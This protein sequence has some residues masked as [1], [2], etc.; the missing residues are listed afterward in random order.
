MK[1]LNQRKKKKNNNNKRER[2]T[3]PEAWQ[4][5]TAVAGYVLLTV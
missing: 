3:D 5:A 1:V 2:E 4:V